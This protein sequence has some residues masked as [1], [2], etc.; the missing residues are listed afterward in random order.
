MSRRRAVQLANRKRIL[1]IAMCALII[2]GSIIAIII[3][4]SENGGSEQS[5]EPVDPD[6]T[7][8]QGVM[9]NGVDVSGLN[10]E[11]AM[12]LLQSSDTSAGDLMIN[13][14]EVEVGVVISTATSDTISEI[15]ISGETG[16]D[17]IEEIDQAA[18]SA[19]GGASVVTDANV[20]EAE[21]HS[22]NGTRT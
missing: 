9:I 10:Y 20:V 19:T 1:V 14:P 7:F 18:M 4:N 11:E 21:E 2:L 5:R 13:T 8:M 12:L 3:V 16:P 17:S 15:D 6:A 22:F